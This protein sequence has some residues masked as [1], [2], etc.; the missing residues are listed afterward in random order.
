MRAKS[1]S[2]LGAMQ[3]QLEAQ[4]R[5][6]KD[7]AQARALAEA[8]RLREQATVCLDG[9]CRKTHQ[10]RGSRKHTNARPVALGVATGV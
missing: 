10:R 8:H 7:A 1:F 3:K 5:A 9:W 2:D 4:A 6:E